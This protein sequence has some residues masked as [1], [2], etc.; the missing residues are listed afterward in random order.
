[1]NNRSQT[2][3]ELQNLVINDFPYFIAIN[4]QRLINESN[5]KE[6]TNRCIH[7]FDFTIRALSLMVIGQYLIVD[8]GKVSDPLLNKLLKDRFPRASLGTWL[9]LCF[10]GIQVY[11]E[12][13][14]SLYIKELV[15]F[16]WDK[17][18]SAPNKDVVK[19]CNRLVEIRN[20]IAHG[21]P[22]QSNEEWKKLFE[23]AHTYLLEILSKLRFLSGYNLIFISE[24]NQ[25]QCKYQVYRGT[26][27][28]EGDMIINDSNLREGWF[29][30]FPKNSD[31]DQEFLRL[32]PFFFGWSKETLVSRTSEVKDAA[33]LDKFTSARIYYLATVVWQAFMVEDE[34]LLAEFFYNYEKALDVKKENVTALDW[35]NLKQIVSEISKLNAGNA[36]SKF[37]SDL[38]YQRNDVQEAFNDFLRSNKK[39]FIL[40]GKS[41]VGKTNFFISQLENSSNPDAIYLFYEGA[42]INTSTL[43]PEVVAGDFQKNITLEHNRIVDLKYIFSFIAK[44]FDVTERR[45]VLIIDAINENESPRIL[46]EQ[47]N[48]FVEDFTYPWLKVAF[49]SRPEAWKTIKRGIRLSEDQYYRQADQDEPGV[50]VPP[51]VFSSELQKFSKEELP[52]VYQRYQN[53]YGLQTNYENV[54]FGVRQMLSDPLILKLV[55]RIYTRKQ[56]PADLKAEDIF[57]KYIDHLVDEEILRIGDLR[58]LENEIMPRILSS[59]MYNKSLHASIIQDAVTETGQPLFELIHN[60]DI[61]ANKQRVNQSFINLADAEI[62]ALFGSS[63][64]YELGFKYERFYDYFAGRRIHKLA[65]TIENRESYYLT[66]IETVQEYPY[67]WG[68][69]KYSLSQEFAHD[70]EKVIGLC[71]S[72]SQRVKE[73]IVNVLTDLGQ[74]NIVDTETII[75]KLVPYL[76]AKNKKGQRRVFLTKQNYKIAWKIS[77]EVASK[78]G[79]GWV[80]LATMLSSDSSMRSMG[81]RYSY[82][83]W[84]NNPILGLEILEGTIQKIIKGFIPDLNAFESATGLSL[85]IFFEHS[86][87]QKTLLKLRELWKRVINKIFGINETSNRLQKV[88]RPWLAERIYTS[89]L[90]IVFGILRD[91]PNYNIVTSYKY[92]ENSIHMTKEEQELYFRLLNYVVGVDTANFT[93]IENDLISLLDKKNIFLTSAAIFAMCS[94]LALHPSAFLKVLKTFFG[95]ALTYPK[96]NSYLTD[97]PNALQTILDHD[98]KNDECFEFYVD[99]IQKCQQYYLDPQRRP[100]L[101]T[102]EYPPVAY[103]GPYLVYQYLREGTIRTKWFEDIVNKALATNDTQFFDALLQTQMNFIGIERRYPNIALN[104]LAFFFK[105]KNVDTDMQIRAFLSRLRIYYPDL[106]D[107]FLEEQGATPDYVLWI[108]THEPEQR[109]GELIGIRVWF[110]LRDEVILRNENLRLLL[111]QIFKNVTSSKTFRQWVDKFIREIVNLVYGSQ[112]LKQ[113]SQ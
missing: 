94:N 64:E 112:I 35:D 34:T 113:T 17:N 27:I 47:I 51:F 109:V 49:S 54:P 101:S 1:M 74:T 97:V 33:L 42:K 75:K 16:Y 40:L 52:F 7:V 20:E 57:Q 44:I 13:N 53:F 8:R 103:L 102:N 15:N 11:A 39:A 86:E 10:R 55:A 83:L 73:M 29:Y 77:V 46:L 82:Y 78:V 31:R 38:Y 96:P 23:E 60:D 36:R 105:Q 24:I 21:L 9:N 32:Y 100:A 14:Y 69:V 81:V 107:D 45:L 71:F 95:I 43:L 99:A 19:S 91:F 18:L 30:L 6:K 62:L 108:K 87:D 22:P 88:I 110:F 67:L 5:W 106:V 61:L 63:V 98:P 68:A 50:E 72:E 56:I 37:N 79:I 93:N 2:I 48:A 92:V 26:I 3:D 41:G 85:I 104:V 12:N 59:S 58:F 76:Q 84:Q 28:K 4:Y 66:L 70:P 90:S 25:N 65:S 111:L 80:L 89:V